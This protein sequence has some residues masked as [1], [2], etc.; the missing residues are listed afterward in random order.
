MNRIYRLV[1]NHATGQ[2]QVASELT[3]SHVSPAGVTG[4]PRRHTALA[5][6]LLT[7]L[8]S[9]GATTTA[10]AQ[11][12]PY[13][14]ND[15][16]TGLVEHPN[17][18]TV[19][20][21]NAVT[22]D[23]LSGGDLSGGTAVVLGTNVGGTGTIN[24]GTASSKLQVLNGPMYVGLRGTGV[25]NVVDGGKAT[26]AGVLSLGY[27]ESGRGTV[28]VRGSGS[29]LSAGA[30]DVG[31]EG[32]STLNITNGGTVVTSSATSG[33]GMR[34]GGPGSGGSLLTTAVNVTTGGTLR[35][36]GANLV[37][38]QSG[39]ATLTVGDGGVANVGANLLV[40]TGGAGFLTVSGGGTVTA[41][42][43]LVVGGAANSVGQLTVSGA[44]ASVTA[45]S[46]QV[47]NVGIGVVAVENG[48]QLTVT[49]GLTTDTAGGTSST[50]T[51]T[52]ANSKLKAGTLEA[53]TLFLG[54]GAVLETG[55]ATIKDPRE[56]LP[57]GQTNNALSMS[58]TG[59]RWDNTGDLR[60]QARA[61]ISGSAHITTGN[62]VVSGGVNSSNGSPN[63]TED[64]VLVSG[65][66]TLVSASGDISVGTSGSEP[67]GLLVA[68]NR[69]RIEAGNAYNLG[70]NG[71]VALGGTG[72]SWSSAARSLTWDAATVAG[73][74][75]GAPINMAFNSGGLVFNHT[76]DISLANTIA[77]DTSGSDWTGGRLINVAGNTTL[78][79]DLSAFGGDVD[80]RAGTLV[81]NSNMYTGQGFNSAA[82]APQQVIDI[83]GGKLVLNGEAGFRHTYSVG[84]ATA[85][86]RTSM[87]TV[88][89]G[90]I[91][92]GNATVGQTTVTNGGV[93][94][95]GNSP[96]TLT[97]DGDLLFNAGASSAA[98]VASAAYYDVEL[99]GNGESDL[100][101]VNG[102]AVIGRSSNFGWTG[103]AAMRIT[104]LDPAI[105]YQNG[106]TYNVLSA[107]EGVVGGFDSVTSNSAFITPTLTQNGD[108][109][110][111]TIAVNGGG[112]DPGNPGN[113]GEPGT[114]GNPG[115]PGTP[116]EPG[117]PGNPGTTPPPPEVF[118]PVATNPNQQNV[119]NG[120][121]SLQQSGE[122]LALY[123]E[124]L[125][126]DAEQAQQAF[127]ELSGESHASNRAML[128]D[129]RFLRDGIAQRLRPDPT[130][131][132]YGP[133]LWLAGSSTSRRQDANEMAARTRDERHGAIVGMDW[134]FGE[135]WK[136]G[137]AVGPEKLR[138]RVSDRNSTTDVDAIHGGLYL[139][140]Q[141]AEFSFHAG[142][143]YA[144]YDVETERSV[145]AG[146]GWAQ[147][148][149]SS[150]SANAVSAFAEAGWNIDLDPLVLT[151]YL[152]L[153]YTRLDTDAVQETGG[154]A[155]L[156]V[157][158]R[159][160]DAWT[161][162]AGLRAGWQLGDDRGIATR[163]EAG[164]AWQ[165]SGGDLPET[166]GR[167]VAGTS[168]FTVQ[169]LPLARNVGVA[170]L[171][172]SIKPTD[173]SRLALMAQGRSGDGQSEFGG[174]LSFNLMF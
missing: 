30:I 104:G 158:A 113:P 140:W 95:P 101:Q 168:S 100:V 74:L 83:S 96:G 4:S 156:A 49:N 148:L 119:A 54:D 91:L 1:F 57:T 2:T 130:M 48:G 131:A 63:A 120:L 26:V 50:L 3:S 77:S 24:V 151:P 92:A 9:A 31:V 123:N 136:W 88:R 171:G 86:E 137:V 41:A 146:Y 143:S 145:G 159:K 61:D 134:S 170:E 147:R 108:Q 67:Y 173:N 162:T 15:S 129:D 19:G 17:G 6:A 115:T 5:A 103:D 18:F 69:A 150:Y 165:H 43:A 32:D 37:I 14:T 163:L 78:T 7:A 174:Q 97:I 46:M 53:G 144:D 106:R 44:G 122:S 116:G 40:G 118:N 82:P 139:G 157:E 75:S 64:R 94:S 128:L 58:G 110:V 109:L 164:L 138:Q 155:A 70:E 29:Q 33:Y 125:M 90:G 99:L 107:A 127:N 121:N 20:D 62:L 59:T 154:A 13:T 55:S 87:V 60:L 89:N 45:D 34:I 72:H 93:L 73:A 68:A 52:G 161:A 47:S 112:T 149:D 141:G 39:Q 166:R 66:G 153:S 117:T 23:I 21:N 102:R 11:S 16:I 27:Q 71:F 79:G 111:L 169:G 42:G 65:S 160:D 135:G 172:V 38:G 51:V 84:G 142:A 10:F 25:L 133:S 36:D 22:V 132:E 114:P 80:V 152:G 56:V 126:L 81:I 85:S 12:Y 35:V 76:G 167:F 8:V 105:S 98:E 28:T 124:L